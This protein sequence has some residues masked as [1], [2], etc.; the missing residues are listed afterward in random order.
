SAGGSAGERKLLQTGFGVHM[1]SG[2]HDLHGLA[3][4]P[5]G[6]IYF[7]MGDRGLSVGKFHYPDTGAVLRCN[8][9][10]SEFEVVATGVRNPEQL[11]FDAHGNLFTGDNNSD[12]G[13]KAR[14]VWIVEGGDSGWRFGYQHNILKSPWMVERQWEIE[15]GA[16]SPSLVPPVGYIGHG[17]SGI[18]F[19]GGTGLSPAYDDHFFMTDFPGGVWSFAVR[20]RG[21]GYE[22]ADLR[23]FLWE[24]W[25]TDVEVGPDGAV[26]VSDWVQGWAKPEKGR[27]FKVTDPARR[28]D[29]EG[30]QTLQIL[31][32]GMEDRPIEEL[33]GLLGHRNQR[34]RLAAQ[35][36]LVRR[37]SAETFM[38]VKGPPLARL[39]AIWGLGQLKKSEPL[40]PLL[41]DPDVEVRA[42]S[43]KLLG[44]L[45]D[46]RAFDGLKAA[47]KDENLRVRM[48]AA[49][50][51][52]KLGRKEAVGPLLE[53]L[54]ENADRDPFVRHGGVAALAWI[55]EVEPLL[56]ERSLDA[57]LVL[58]R[59][60]RPEVES[61][62]ESPETA[63]EA[64]R[65]IYD[66]PIS[67]GM[68]SLAARLSKASGPAPLLL[69]AL[70]AN[71]RLGRAREIGEFLAREDAPVALRSEALAML[72]DWEHPSGR[73]RVMGLWR[74]I[75]PRDPGPAREALA[76]LSK[77]PEALRVDFLR[78]Q[79]ALK[80]PRS[81]EALAR[82]LEDP[83]EGLRREA[84]RLVVQSSVPGKAAFLEK[85]S[86]PKNPTSVR[87]QAIASMGE[88]EGTDAT[89]GALLD[90]LL[91]GT[92]PPALHFDVLEAAGKRSAPALRGRLARFEA[93][94][95]KD[96][97]L[98]P[99]REVLEGGDA[100]SGR[101][102]FFER[103]DVACMRCHLVKDRGGTVGP[104]LTKI[105]GEKT[106]EYLL[107]SILFP[108]KVIAQGYGQE[109]FALENGDV[110]SG[111]I[112]AETQVEVSLILPDGQKKKIAKSGI[113]ARKPGLSAMPE[114][115]SKPLSKRD[116]RDLV[117][118]L[119]SLR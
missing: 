23:E 31:S 10:G 107:E 15:A 86:T 32:R 73:D 9:D 116:L 93:S 8:P 51:L 70:A 94:R 40:L 60:E 17:P 19:Y 110:L 79:V 13:D 105:G 114:D 21:G 95:K 48:Y 38:A 18:A 76:A 100:K 5:D 28:K 44:D 61:Y 45:R 46:A 83:D 3:I 104:P 58:R 119:A 72:A 89:L 62:L 25:P 30:V 41:S 49:L 68:P 90:E 33:S 109:T 7:T 63:L 11:A 113:R 47:L 27:I 117:A 67:S 92:L 103:L 55:G 81:G 78:A 34:V 65:A 88:V 1:G 50:S 4:G 80:D 115:I 99:Y 112:E 102:I 2:A 118:F 42:Q 43:A 24:M 22:L 59:L 87:Q 20:P 35:F 57:L 84:V 36:E 106:R 108:N 64:A 75:A 71:F 6:K 101:A 66:V 54:R 12:A 14:W 77:V 69:R 74:P 37:G 53:M 26:Y 91:G 52:G 111:R 39:H 16:H 98:A 85:L 82:A 96:D 29:P 56:K 97:P